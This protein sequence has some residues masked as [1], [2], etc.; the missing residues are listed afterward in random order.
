MIRARGSRK[1][2]SG[3]TEARPRCVALR[4]IAGF[5]LL[6]SGC[7]ESR[8]AQEQVSKSTG[9][10]IIIS[11]DTL[12]A[13]HLPTYGATGVETPALDALSRDSIVFENAYSQVPL[14]L[15]SHASMLT[16]RLPSE[17]GIRN[18]LG[19]RF[20]PEVPSLPL[21]LARD[22]WDTGAAVSAYVLRSETGLG[23]AF[24]HYDDQVSGS[25]GALLGEIQRSGEE[26]VTA[27]LSWID[28]RPDPRFFFFLHLFDPHAPYEPPEPFASRYSAAPYDGEIAAADA[29]L[30]RFLAHLRSAGLYDDATILFMSDHGEGLG[31]HGELQHGIFLYREVIRVPL[32]LKLPATRLAGTRVETP[33]ALLDVFPT[34]L[35][36]AGVSG[37]PEPASRAVSL[38]DLAEGARPDRRIF[39]ETMYPRIHL[40]WSDLASLVDDSFHFIAAP[41]AELYDVRADPAEKHNVI[42][43]QR[44]VYAALDREMKTFDRSLTP[45][46]AISPEEEAKLSAL[47]YLGGAGP[48]SG[49]DLP[50]PKDRIADLERFGRALSL[51][52]SGS[53]ETAIPILR[54]I[55]DRN[56]SFADA[57]TLLAKSYDDSGRLE[58]AAAAYRRA[59]DAAPALAAGTMLS[60]SEVYV[61]LN[62]W[63]EAIAHADLAASMHPAQA[64]LIR[65]RAFLA[66]R[67]A[68]RAEGELQIVI[69]DPATRL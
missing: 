22:R 39:S 19:Y 28:E 41:R 12:R 60:L 3:S 46:S 32:F 42:A 20:D 17:L 1:H 47:G 27:A 40:G 57:W 16:G 29:A 69:A 52:D 65:S 6:A 18:N 58:D 33:A 66:K 64:A 23:E 21:L 26:T 5:L 35:E 43:E 62:R 53:P 51:R 36:I 25:Q 14:T 44:R 24:D 8:L 4:L 2:E 55:V 56:P 67:D 11:V 9:P 30:G 49:A 45:P 15:P 38:V 59:V 34:L 61:K 7:R 31:D 50:D 54:E 10:I 37:T 68:A 48:G 63:D 13:D